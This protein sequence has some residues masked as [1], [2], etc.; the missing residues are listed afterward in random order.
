ME[1]NEWINNRLPQVVNELEKSIKKDFSVMAEDGLDLAGRNDI[2]LVLDSLLA[3]L[4]PGCYSR[5][6]VGNGE[7]NFFLGDVLRHVSFRLSKH[8]R[9]VFK[10]RCMRDNCDNCDC[11]TRAKDALMQLI[12]TLPKI[13]EVLLE[14]INAAFEGDPAAKSLDEIVLAYRG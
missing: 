9:D 4:F 14:D 7:V 2:Y 12:E 13:R 3:A 6:K 5:D 10:Y 1:I 8:I 11:D